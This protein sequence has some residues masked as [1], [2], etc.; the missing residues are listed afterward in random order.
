MSNLPEPTIVPAY[1]GD[2]IAILKDTRIEEIPRGRWGIIKWKDSVTMARAFNLFNAHSSRGPMMSG[3]MPCHAKVYNWLLQ[4]A[5][6]SVQVGQ[7]ST[8]KTPTMAFADPE[9]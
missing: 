7:L 6:E 5:F 4:V 1:V 8:D 2:A 3:C 9:E